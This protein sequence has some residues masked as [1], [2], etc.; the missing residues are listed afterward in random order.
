ML[1]GITIALAGACVLL[2][3]DTGLAGGGEETS[4]TF[5]ITIVP[6]A[7]I[8]SVDLYFSFT[9]DL[10]NESY[11]V[12]SAPADPANGSITIGEHHWSDVFDTDAGYYVELFAGRLYIRKNPYLSGTFNAGDAVSWQFT[13]S[14]IT[15]PF[16]L[17]DVYVDAR[18]TLGN[19]V[20]GGATVSV[21]T[22]K[23]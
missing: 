22:E 20:D 23:L 13:I 1:L 8:Q 15:I 12:S 16:E 19:P 7:G 5:E 4:V 3:C 2:A 18:D 6:D 21:S 9:P 14:N 11:A 17:S 10:T